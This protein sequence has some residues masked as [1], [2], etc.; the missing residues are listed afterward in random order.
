MKSFFA[1]TLFA[2]ALTL[3]AAPKKIAPIV[4]TGPDGRLV[5]D[6]DA[7]GNRV[8]DFSTCSYAGGARPIPA[9]PARVCVPAQA[10]D[11]T[12]R[13][14][15]AID[16]VGALPPDAAGF[17]GAVLLLHGRHEIFGGL[18]ITNSGVVLR[19]EGEQETV[20]VAAGFDRRTLIRLAGKNDF[21]VRSN[22][23]WQ[24]ADAFVPVNATSFQLQNA[25]GLQVGDTI[26]VV[27][28]ST[29]EWIEALGMTELGGGLNDWRIVWKPGSRDLNWDR[30]I[31]KVDGNRVTLN[32]PVTTAIESKF[33]GGWVAT[34]SWPGRIKNSGVENLRLESAF[35]AANPKDENHSWCAI[36]LENA[37]DA[38]VRQV[39]FTH[40]AG[41]A[42]AIFESCQQISVTDCRSLAPV[43][44][45]AGGRRNTFFTMGQ[46][47]LFLRCRAESGRHDFAV[48]HGAAGPNAFVE[49][50]AD[51]PTADSGAIASWSSGTLFDQVRIDGQRLNLM[52]RGGDDA[53]AGWSAAN[54]VLWNCIAAKIT[55]ENPHGAQNWAFG[56][57]GEFAGN[58]V[59]RNSNTTA[60]P[61]SLFAGQL[62]D[63]LGKP[64]MEALLTPA[65][66]STE[67]Q[68]AQ[69]V[70]ELPDSQPK[71]RSPKMI[72]AVTNGW[73]VC[74]GK[75]LLGGTQPINW[76][77]GN[78]LPSD[79]KNY[80]VNVT[81]FAPGRSGAGWTDDLSEIAAGMLA[82]N[83]VALD[84]HYGL[85]YDRRR[86]DH[87]RVRR[88]TGDAWPPFYEQPFARS[89]RGLAWDGLSR[90]DLTQFNP[91]YWSRLEQFAE[92]CDARGLVLFNENYFQHNILEDGAHWVDSP[93]RSV[94]NINDTGFRE[95]PF[96]I[97]KR[98][99]M[100]DQ[101][102][103]MTQPVRRAL[104]AKFIRQNLE[105]FTNHAN[106]IQFTSA[107]F[108]GP[109]AFAQF[110]LDTIAAW[111]RET[112]QHPLIALAAPKDVQDAILAEE[113]RA[114]LVDVICFR[115]WW[116]TD[117]GL[118]APP[119]G[120]NLSPRQSERQWK[121]GAPDDKN[122][123]AMAA[124]YRRK[125]S[126]KA[127][128][129]AGED[130]DMSRAAWAF[131]CAGG[132]M[133]QL[134]RT[135]DA[136]LLAAIPRMQ[137]WLAD[138][139]RQRWGLRE[140]G[141]QLFIHTGTSTELD[142]TAEAG[143]FRVQLVNPATGV[144]MAGEKILA[145]GTVKLP[146]AALIWLTKE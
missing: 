22:A 75:L 72:I 39:T 110:W 118:F 141:R 106:V 124:E 91:W 44:E 135:T 7:S 14:Q 89:G 143:A 98:T 115:Y 34:Y 109:L 26:R 8:P 9:V 144:V 36:T 69:S 142:F 122:L 54:S 125:F 64:A 19:G 35:A 57:W 134:P 107:E 58:G 81:R 128:I 132:S 55:C 126:G 140:P 53:G 102:Y 117:R 105:N 51:L 48:G 59:W 60:K 83:R 43:A 76:W 139:A 86:E 92:I 93:W 129:A 136:G 113:K 5:Y 114:A 56:S 23:S 79:A 38:W 101:F 77:K 49:C 70:D 30:V 40:F 47:T 133:P 29:K 96:E 15:K 3:S 52:N 137:P 62:A 87:E 82:E 67:S 10:G 61:E 24:I 73:L 71:I 78:L 94:N 32:A 121:G 130:V 104:H 42:V 27:R 123:A 66:F 25:A 33:G 37:A 63:R 108:T 127:I 100:A 131:V 120:Q 2:T 12:A 85:W 46:Q 103:D 119:G 111:E 99:V 74:A 16:Y 97:E 4:A 18:Q 95:P 90:Y 68:N 20:L 17:R 1:L 11:E 31:Q 116:Q 146:D 65:T 50:E 45:D 21:S 41:S 112:Q 88:M 145:G 28:P 13:I 138:A 84:H 6:V 80:G